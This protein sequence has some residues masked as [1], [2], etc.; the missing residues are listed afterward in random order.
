MKY[1]VLSDTHGRVD[2]S[3]KIF[4]KHEEETGLEAIIHL[5]DF[6]SDAKAIASRTGAKV[7]SVPGNMDG[8]FSDSDYQII[9]EE[10]GP[11]LIIH[12]HIQA[13]KLN[14]QRLLYRTEE[15]GCKA[16]LFGHT[17][18]PLME[19]VNGIFL[20]NPGSLTRPIH[21]KGSYALLDTDDANFRASILFYEAQ[22]EGTGGVLYNMLNNSD[23]A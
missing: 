15:L 1:L 9:D 21:G 23:R 2:S 13:V 8:C 5:G 22:P 11:I 19:Y 18:K 16:V 20:L 7:I 12:G 14:L 4:K 17:H 10:F 6:V 3:I